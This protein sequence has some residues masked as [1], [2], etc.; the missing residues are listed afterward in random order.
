MEEAVIGFHRVLT[1]L[2]A[3]SASYCP[4]EGRL[5]VAGNFMPLVH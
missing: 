1:P 3:Q 4:L 2:Y 5:R